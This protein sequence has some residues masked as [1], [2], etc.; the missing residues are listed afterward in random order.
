MLI[1]FSIAYLQRPKA[2]GPSITMGLP[3]FNLCAMTTLLL[4]PFLISF[5]SQTGTEAAATYLYHVCPNTTT[6]TANSTYQSNLNSL[7]ASLTS[8]ATSSTGFYNTTASP[9]NSV[10]T[11]YG[12]F[13]CR[14]D[15]SADACRD[16]AADATKDVVDRCPNEKVAVAWYDE[17]MLRY[18]NQYIFSRMVTDPSIFMWNTR[19]IS[20]QNRFDLLVRTT[21]NDLA[22]GVSN[23]GSGAKKFG[24]KEANFTALQTLYALVQCTADLSGSDCNSCLQIAIANLPGCCG[25]KEGARVLFPSCTVRFEVY[26]F[27]QSVATFP[28]PPGS[29]VA[30]VPPLP[31]SVTTPKGKDQISPLTIIAIVVPISVTVVLFVM[32]YYFLSRRARKKYNAVREENADNDITTVESL[33]FNLATIETATNMFSDDNKLGKGG[34]GVVYKGTLLDGHEI[35]VKRLSKSSRQGTGEFK[36]EVELVAKL[37]H[38]NLV[39]LLGFCLAGEE[40]ILVYEFMPNKSLDYFLYDPARKGQLDWSRRYKIIRGIARGILYLHEDSQLRIIH[41]DLKASNILL[42]KDMNPKISDFGMAKIFGVDQTQGNASRIVG[43]FGYMAPEYAMHGQFSVKS[44]VYSFGVLVLEIITGKKISSF[45]QSDEDGDLLSYAWKHWRDGTSMEWLDPNLE[46]SYSR[47][48]VTRC[49]H[50]GLLSVQDNPADR[51]TM[52]SIVVMLNSYSVTLAS[53]QQ[54]ASFLSTRTEQSM[55]LKEWVSSHQST[56]KSTPWSVNE[57]SITEVYP[58]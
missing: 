28:P 12:L 55:P 33:Q 44:D 50:I 5:L 19:N 21:M 14:G 13:L 3:S 42:D 30:P 6:F 11:V 49:L 57:A 35:A 38:R 54:P 16:C 1:K 10:D 2:S 47:N 17:C 25:G 20:E 27:Y 34:F 41:R 15:L 29:V 40:K 52:A 22:S 36:N 43:T 8:N 23:V 48:E 45:Y 26:P 46:D 7:L 32:G 39:R 37:Q 51:P 4:L 9:G 18:S 56:S 53:P 58:R 31:G 24:T